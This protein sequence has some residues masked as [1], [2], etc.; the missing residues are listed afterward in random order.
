MTVPTS[1]WDFTL[2]NAITIFCGLVATAMVWQ[3]LKD[4][5]DMTTEKTE[6]NSD[7]LDSIL[8]LALHTSVQQHERRILS[9][10]DTIRG[11]ALTL[12]GMKMDVSWIKRTIARQE[13]LSASD[14]SP[15]HTE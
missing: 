13:R 5:L 6:K 12:E 10:E 3:K 11:V 14:D 15:T 4:K 8:K 7:E 1:F 9:M 2:G